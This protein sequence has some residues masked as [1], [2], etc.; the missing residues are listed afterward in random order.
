MANKSFVLY[1]FPNEMHL[2][3]GFS[4]SK[5][6]GKAHLRN[7]IK[8]QV[9]MMAQEIFD[10]DRSCDYIIIVRKQYLRNDYQSNY[11]MLESLYKKTL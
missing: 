8:R 1:Y 11:Q 10:K 6:L 5:K 2:R 9:R 4:V 7:K 3:V